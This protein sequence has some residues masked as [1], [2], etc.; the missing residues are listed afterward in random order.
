MVNDED[1][2]G[3]MNAVYGI[4]KSLGLDLLLH[5]P[6]GNLAAAES[7]VD[8]LKM[9][10]GNDIRAI[11]PQIAMSAGTMI[12]CA[13]KEIVMGKESNMGPIDP[14][15]G[16]IPAS[17]VIEEF[18]RACDEVK[19]DPDKFPMWQIILSNYYPTLLGE[20]EKAMQW[21]QAIVTDWLADNMLSGQAGGK[22][23]AAAIAAY[24]GDHKATRSHNRHIGRN[25]C[26]EIGL[27]IVKLEEH[28]NGGDFQDA[29]LSVHHA[30]MHSFYQ[31]RNILKII[32]NQNGK[33]AVW[34]ESTEG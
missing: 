31:D 25:A 7:L 27:K 3:F 18:E 17:G 24:L 14:Q 10:F 28:G 34:M 11:V 6:G 15:F 21:S 2:N 23:A 22:A 29:V 32:E 5:T 13:C 16:G 19:K 1:K 30:Y 9:M 4:D 33:A 12:A 8:Y 26:E 20:C